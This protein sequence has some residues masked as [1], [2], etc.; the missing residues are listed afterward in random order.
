MHRGAGFGLIKLPGVMRPLKTPP[1]CADGVSIAA[2]V[3]GA[4]PAVLAGAGA[5]VALWW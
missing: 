3:D 5:A 1:I 4:Q 2:I